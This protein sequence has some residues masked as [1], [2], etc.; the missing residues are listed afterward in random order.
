MQVDTHKRVMLFNQ[1]SVCIANKHIHYSSKGN[2]S[3]ISKHIMKSVFLSWPYLLDW[4][5]TRFG[6]VSSLWRR[7]QCVGGT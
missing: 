6:D 2:Y 3:V 4:K 7:E 5:A 1:K